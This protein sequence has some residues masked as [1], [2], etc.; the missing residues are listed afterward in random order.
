MSCFRG[1]FGGLVAYLCVTALVAGGLGWVTREALQ[2]EN[3]RR[4]AAASREHEKLQKEQDERWQE[5][6][7]Q[8]A[9]DRGVKMRHALML[10]DSRL[11]PALS[12]EDSRPSTH[13][14]AL[15]SPFP[16]V[17]PTGTAW[18]PGQVLIPSPLMTA[19]LPEWMLLHFQ[20]DPVK[21]WT[22]P[23]VIPDVLQ[24]MLRRQ[25]IELAL[26]NVDDAHRKRLDEL[27]A[28]YPARSFLATLRT[29]GLEYDPQKEQQQELGQFNGLNLNQNYGNNTQNIAPTQNTAQS[30]NSIAGFNNDQQRDAN[31]SGKRLQV[32]NRGKNEGLWAF[33]NDGRSYS[34]LQGSLPYKA[35]DLKQTE[36]RELEK[37]LATATTEAKKKDVLNR[38]DSTRK[39]VDDLKRTLQPVEVKLSSM[40]PLWLPSPEN[41]KHLLLMR[42]MRIG[43]LPAYQG[44]LLDWNRL[45]DILK[46]EIEDVLPDAK[47]IIDAGP[48]P[49]PEPPES[50][51][52]PTVSPAGWTPLRIGLALAWVAAFIAW[53]AVGLGGWTLLDLSERRIRFVSAVT[54]ELRTPLTT[55]RLYLD[56]LNSGLVSEEKQRDEYIKT[57]GAEADRLYRLI[58]NV[59]DFARL[60]KARPTVE[61][62]EI[63]VADLLDQ[64]LK[65]WSERCAATG[66]ELLIANILPPESRVTTDP[67]LVEQIL[68]NLIDNARKY[69]QDA[70]DPRIWLRARLENGK[71]ILEVEDRGPG[72]TKRER[73]SIF[74]AFRRGHDADVRAGGVGL[75][76]A[77]ATRWAGFVGGRLD[78]GASEA[79]VGACFRLEL[80]M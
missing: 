12:R 20:V 70:A 41:P 64:L 73:G 80:P 11:T 59:L 1:K 63:A 68:G 51:P 2:M 69:S 39:E 56:L 30:Q 26:N 23:Q 42:P 13:F 46:S 77:L 22:S 65:T 57:L 48:L 3:E 18:E 33:L 40:Q 55:L 75:G 60:E 72:V 76:L 49:Q 35:L 58:G 24:K 47:F 4:I 34:S 7:Q 61:K 14:E 37:Q 9:T 31:D 21:G 28:A 44:I 71:L 8:I 17:T 78:V 15:H 62:R 79:G 54:H 50:I 27:K 6:L 10:L 38:L 16:A 32:I 29:E 66:K 25:P 45:R 53:L 43:K 52:A 19:E 5:R 67:S 36:C 74:R